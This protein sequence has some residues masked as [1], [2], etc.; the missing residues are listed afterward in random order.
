MAKQEIKDRLAQKI[1]FFAS[2]DAQTRTQ[3]LNHLAEKK[4]YVGKGKSVREKTVAEIHL[5]DEFTKRAVNK[6]SMLGIPNADLLI[7]AQEQVMIIEHS[8]KKGPYGIT[9]REGAYIEI[10]LPQGMT[11]NPVSGIDRLFYH[12]IGHFVQKR[13]FRDFRQDEDAG[14]FKEEYKHVAHGFKRGEYSV[15]PGLDD[16]GY[17]EIFSMYCTEKEEDIFYFET[18]S[19][20]I[21]F[22]NNIALRENISPFTAF[23]KLFR[24]QT[25]RDFKFVRELRQLYSHEF[26]KGLNNLPMTS[27]SEPKRVDADLL[28]RIGG[29]GDNYKN[30]RDSLLAGEEIKIEGME[31]SLKLS[32]P[33]KHFED[34]VKASNK[35]MKQLIERLFE[36]NVSR[37]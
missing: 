4:P 14:Y 5:I 35:R 13:V 37:L 11:F 1:D 21:A 6:L 7:P 2:T 3:I 15:D 23:A 18:T 9:G 34:P 8:N 31:G 27:L 17:C 26:L 28:A 22:I 25:I 30:I 12:E 32:N 10:N 20:A 33:K 36:K 24:A 29:F 16:E 19:F